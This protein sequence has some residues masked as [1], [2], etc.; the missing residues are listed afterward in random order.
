MRKKENAF[1]FVKKN[2]T[3][4]NSLSVTN[5][6]IKFHALNIFSIHLPLANITK[7]FRPF[8]V[9]YFSTFSH[10]SRS[11]F[12]RHNLFINYIIHL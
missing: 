8:L 12:Y 10:L 4:V 1:Q 2:T 11:G 3:T 6:K 5:C 7:Y 9:I